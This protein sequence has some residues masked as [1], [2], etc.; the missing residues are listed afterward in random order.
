MVKIC[1]AVGKFCL[2]YPGKLFRVCHLHFFRKLQTIKQLRFFSDLFMHSHKD[3]TIHTSPAKDGH[4]PG[5]GPMIKH[6]IQPE[7][8]HRHIGRIH[9]GIYNL[10]GRMNTD[11]FGKS[12]I[13][14]DRLCKLLLQI[15]CIH[16][17]PI[18]TG[19]KLIES[20]FLL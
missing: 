13:M 12:L 8:L 9:S 17:F 4:I 2:L 5:P 15:F 14:P 16:L 7:A 1:Q 3:G 20:L 19:E 10:L 6:W 18:R 11:S